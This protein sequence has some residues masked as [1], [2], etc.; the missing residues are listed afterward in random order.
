MMREWMAAWVAACRWAS[1]TRSAQ[2]GWTRRPPHC[3]RPSS[4]LCW[5]ASLRPGRCSGS[6]RSGDLHPPGLLPYGF[7]P[8]RLVLVRLTKDIDTLAAMEV[9]LREGVAAAVVGEVGQFDR[10]ASRR[11]QLACLRHGTTGFV[12]RRWPHGHETADREASVAV[13]RWHLTPMPSVKDAKEPG[14][15]RW[16]VAL[17]HV[18]GGRPGEWIMEASDDATHPLRVVAALA[19]HAS[20]PQRFYLAG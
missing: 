9:A 20:E 11:L 3:P 17:T 19:D 6:R 8:N 1:C 7:D 12:L 2:R 5:R 4:L 18:R 13:T 10:T 14:L 15:P 16:H